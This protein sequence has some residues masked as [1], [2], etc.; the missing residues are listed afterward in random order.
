M[1]ECQVSVDIEVPVEWVYRRLLDF[2][3]HGDF[4]EGLAE[5]RQTTPGPIGVGSRF[6]A[7]E[8]VPGRYTSWSEIT[9]LDE[10]RLIA[11]RAWVE[12]VMRTEWE[13]RLS[14]IDGGTRLVEVSRWQPAGWV[15]FLMLN[16][17]RKRHAPREN[18]RTLSR[19]KAVLEGERSARTREVPA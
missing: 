11:W 19:I 1:W 15:G 7:E 6:R 17:H 16:L 8:R 3:R 14:P 13:L 12:G 9:R 18:G 4:S 2:E 5:V 10:P